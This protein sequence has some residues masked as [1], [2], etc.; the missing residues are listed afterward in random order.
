MPPGTNPPFIITY[1]A[2]SVPIVQLALSSD[3]LT[4]QSL[5]D[6]AINFIRVQMITVPGAVVP[7]PY[8]G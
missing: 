8:G 4:E 3:T 2:S 5:F 1:N 6:V 7:Y